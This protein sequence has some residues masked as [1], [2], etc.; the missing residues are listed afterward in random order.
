MLLVLLTNP[1]SPFL[2]RVHVIS[3]TLDHFHVPYFL[4]LVHQVFLST[5][6]AENGGPQYAASNRT[7]HCER[8]QQVYLLHSCESACSSLLQSRSTESI[9]AGWRHA[10]AP[11][12][13]AC[14]FSC[15]WHR[16]AGQQESNATGATAKPLNAGAPTAQTT[17]P[18]GGRTTAPPGIAVTTLNSV[19]TITYVANICIAVD[20]S[21]VARL[22]P[23][24]SLGGYYRVLDPAKVIG[25]IAA[26]V[27]SQARSSRAI[28]SSSQPTYVQN[29]A[30]RV[31]PWVFSISLFLNTNAAL[32]IRNWGDFTSLAGKISSQAGRAPAGP[33]AALTIALVVI[34]Q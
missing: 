11:R 5:N 34:M 32:T 21:T 15:C 18:S 3:L 28:T 25:S 27:Q 14:R 30:R 29:Y 16:S 22:E 9:L 10:D 4:L 33:A 17:A 8:F 1:F 19:Q 23:N 12:C 20:N 7:A 2:C 24:S 31:V 6:K 13:H 26:G